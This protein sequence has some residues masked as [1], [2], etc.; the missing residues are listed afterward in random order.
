METKHRAVIIYLPNGNEAK[1][2]TSEDLCPVYELAEKIVCNEY[3]V[4]VVVNEDGV[5]TG[6][7]YAR[8]PYILEM[9]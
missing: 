4:D 2:S 6:C 1:Y 8:M 3:S 9:F 7:S 5:R